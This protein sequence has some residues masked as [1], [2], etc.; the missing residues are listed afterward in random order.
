[1]AGDDPKARTIRD[2][3]RT[4]LGVGEVSAAHDLDLI[5]KLVAG[6]YVIEERLG[7]GA[8]GAVYRGHHAKLKRTVAIKV[9]HPHLVHDATILR[10]FH[11]EAKL[12][13]RLAHAHVAA[14]LDVGETLDGRQLMVLEFAEGRRLSD[15]LTEPLP[16]PRVIGLV[17]QILRGLDH[18]HEVGLIHRDL[19]PDNI[20]VEARDDGTEIARIVDFGIA[21]LRDPDESI[22]GG[23]LTAS[24]QMMGTPLYMSPEQ[25]TCEPFDHRTD[26]FALGV[27]TYEMLAGTAP[28]D[29]SAIEVALAN[30]QSDPPA[31]ATRAPGV[32]VDPLLEAFCRKL[33]ARALDR[34]FASA[35]DALAALDLIERDREAAGPALGICD[36]ARALDVIS[37]PPLPR[38]R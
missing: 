37:L 15:A 32:Q 13:G 34:R 9:L 35:R 5:G 31:I 14:V 2:P 24:G 4:E 18:A 6:R 29:G 26:L 20:L 30:I 36:V 25:A 28:F 27:I 38:R 22:E 17:R 11:R 21:V 10:R 7:A 16:G 1:M 19:K 12:A 3:R 23:R 33:M 8:F